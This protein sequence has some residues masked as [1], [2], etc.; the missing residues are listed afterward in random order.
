MNPLLTIV[1]AFLTSFCFAQAQKNSDALY[2][3]TIS[4][5]PATI[6]ILT[7]TTTL[8]T[9]FINNVQKITYTDIQAG[10]YKIQISGQGQPTIIKD[11]IIVKAGQQLVLNFKIAGPCLY[12]HPADYIPTCPKNHK[13]SIISIVYGLVATRGDTFIK[14]RKDLKVKY[15]GCVT[16][17]CDPRFYCKEHDIEF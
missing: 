5:R 8:V 7:D 4:Y 2:D 3:L 16:T 13:D 17:D 6:K 14:D 12:N 11:S 10:H 15:A 9:S 1:F